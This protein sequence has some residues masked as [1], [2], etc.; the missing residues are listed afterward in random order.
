LPARVVLDP[1]DLNPSPP[2]AADLGWKS[3][4]ASFHMY[5]SDSVHLKQI[6]RGA[7]KIQPRCTYTQ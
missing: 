5:E 7:W 6:K 4:Q 1:L 2:H 3:R